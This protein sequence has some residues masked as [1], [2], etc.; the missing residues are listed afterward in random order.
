MLNQERIKQMTKLASY[1][2][3]E[4]KEYLPIS[5][6]YRSDYIGMALIKNFFL[7]TIAYGIVLTLIL[8]YQSEFLLDHVYQMDVTVAVVW[9]IISYIA[10]LVFYSCLTYAYYAVKYRRAKKSVQKYYKMISKLDKLYA[11]EDKKSDG[12]QISRRLKE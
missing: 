3:G 11:K 8:G 6:Y 9:V 10:V 5:K 2:A 4:G 1:E 12:K 7:V